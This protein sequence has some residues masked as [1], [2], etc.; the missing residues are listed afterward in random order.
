MALRLVLADD[1]YI[2]R[3]GT[4]ALLATVQQLDV[5]GVASDLDSLLAAVDLHEPDVLLTDIRTPPRHDDE[6]IV[7]AHRLRDSHPS[8]GVVVLSSHL[9]AR[10]AHELFRDGAAG[11]GYLLKDRISDVE[12]VTRALM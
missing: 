1:D 12:E 3:E 2:V 7:A 11:R 5:V 4:A 10:Y 6:G 9:D 8:I